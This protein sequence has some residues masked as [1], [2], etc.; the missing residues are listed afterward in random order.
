MIRSPRRPA[1]LAALLV[2]LALGGWLGVAFNLP[3]RMRVLAQRSWMHIE[4]PPLDVDE[5]GHGGMAT[6]LVLIDPMG[7]N[8]APNGDV[9]I[10]DRGRRLRGR[11]IWRIDSTGRAHAVAGNG[12]HGTSDAGDLARR[13]R[14]GTPAGL[15]FDRAGR[16]HFA[17]E[18]QHR[19]F[20]LEPDG[21]L[22]IVAGIGLRGDA[23]DGGPAT[24]ARLNQ[25]VDIRFDAHGNLYIADVSNHR[26]RRVRPDGVIETVA[27]T[28]APGYDGDGGPATSARL[29]EPWGIH[30]DPATG[31]L[32]IADSGN[33]VVRRVDRGGTIRT[34]AGTG[35]AGYS[36][37]GGPADAARFDSPQS[38]AALG[39]RTLLIGDEH[40]HAL[41]AIDTLGIV[42]T[43]VGTG[44]AGL[45]A[46]GI[47][48]GEA[49]LNDPENIAAGA[50]GS[51]YITD[52]DNGRVVRVTPGGT[53]SNFAGRAARG[54]DPDEQAGAVTQSVAAPE[55]R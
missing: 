55:G 25:P 2:L 11:V 50:D 27:G 47:P 21:R 31:E 46:D 5:L 16:L 42:T 10:S 22:S 49:P 9:Y 18:E 6:A 28:G 45:A 44:A 38:F 8:V 48:A 43:L 23:G 30:I 14:L 17:D 15:A 20:R 34:I 1:A 3:A 24:D 52:G 40:N 13:A 41:R 32:L 54:D 7:I 12:R 29:R 39:P 33:H 19:V 36:G 53:V 51:V 4:E 35:Q 26:I 37:D